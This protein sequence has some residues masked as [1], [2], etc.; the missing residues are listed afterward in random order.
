MFV[1]ATDFISVFMQSISGTQTDSRPTQNVLKNNWA[2]L[3]GSFDSTIMI[4]LKTYLSRV[5][6]SC[7]SYGTLTSPCQLTS[8]IEVFNAQIDYGI[9]YRI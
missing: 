6:W 7:T 5:K 8:M 2:E 4:E 1:S 3:F 9:R